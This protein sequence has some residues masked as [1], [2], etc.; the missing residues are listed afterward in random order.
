[1]TRD[2]LMAFY[3]Q[4]ELRPKR[5]IFYRDGVS[6]GQFNQVLLKEMDAIRTVDVF[7]FLSARRCN[8]IIYNGRKSTDRSGNISPGTVVDMTICHPTEFDFYLC[9]HA[10]IQGVEKVKPPTGSPISMLMAT[11]DGSYALPS[12]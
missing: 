10:G 8:Q 11:P 4:T 2:Y 12:S 5:I 1:M 3:Q 7:Y 6:E 9:S